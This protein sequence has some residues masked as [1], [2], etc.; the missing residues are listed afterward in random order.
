MR[1]QRAFFDLGRFWWYRRPALL[2][3]TFTGEPHW[4]DLVAS[5]EGRQLLAYARDW[6]EPP[7]RGAGEAPDWRQHGGVLFRDDQAAQLSAARSGTPWDGSYMVHREILEAKPPLYQQFA[8]MPLESLTK[9]R[10]GIG[11]MA[12]SEAFLRGGNADAQACG[13]R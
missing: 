12:G 2:E 1:D 10:S 3:G 7:A 13:K 5:R 4:D 9:P 6:P 11:V 8:D